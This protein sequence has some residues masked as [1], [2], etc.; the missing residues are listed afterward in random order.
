MILVRLAIGTGASGPDSTVTPSSGTEIAA[1][2]VTGHGSAGRVP[3]TGVEAGKA[4]CIAGAGTARLSCNPPSEATITTTTNVTHGHRRRL[5]AFGGDSGVA[6]TR[7][8]DTGG[9]TGAGATSRSVAVTAPDWAAP[10]VAPLRTTSE[11][12]GGAMTENPDN[13]VATLV[14]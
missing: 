12:S 11:G 9:D 2:P 13:D 8:G 1:S 10:S 3:A 4:R 7:G 5:S 14:A 6:S